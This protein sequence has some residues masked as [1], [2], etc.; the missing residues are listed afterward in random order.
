[1]NVE[2]GTEAK[3]FPEKEQINGIFVAVHRRKTFIPLND[4]FFKT[5]QHIEQTLLQDLND[6]LEKT[7]KLLEKI[8]HKS[9]REVQINQKDSSLIWHGKN[10]D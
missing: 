2:T 10:V 1:M 7:T 9:R 6:F 3:Q 5:G 4:I 8:L